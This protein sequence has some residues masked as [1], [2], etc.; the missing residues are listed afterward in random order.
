MGGRAQDFLG[1]LNSDDA[2]LT[3]NYWSRLRTLSPK[4]A[5]KGIGWQ[6]LRD[7]AEKQIEAMNLLAVNKKT[8]ISFRPMNDTAVVNV[9][10]LKGKVVLIDFWASW[11]KPCIGEFARLKTLYE[12][13]HK[14]GFEIIGIC[15][16]E[17]N[18]RSRVASLLKE[19]SIVCWI[20]QV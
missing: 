2:E 14:D 7:T 3:R 8:N 15:L 17:E 20:L 10:A 12:K 4:N 19:H 6:S 16:D 13:Y 9:S 5:D 18:Q 1:S 11:C